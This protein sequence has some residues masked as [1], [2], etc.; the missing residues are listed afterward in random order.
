MKNVEDQ[1]AA[2]GFN[3]ETLGGSV[4]EAGVFVQ[5]VNDG[6]DTIQSN[7]GK[8]LGKF[9]H[10]TVIPG[11]EDYVKRLEAYNK[12]PEN[13]SIPIYYVKLAETLKDWTPWQLANA[14]YKA[15]TGKEFKTKPDEIK[16]LERNTNVY[17]G[18]L[19]TNHGN[20]TKV[21]RAELIN[22]NVD[23]NSPQYIS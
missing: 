15:S 20:R 11:S 2:G 4:E 14:Q 21:K 10:S 12:D 18:R 8:D 5:K 1:M 9:L 19:I 13:N 22:S 16:Y 7:S 23:F 3:T 6:I 17:T